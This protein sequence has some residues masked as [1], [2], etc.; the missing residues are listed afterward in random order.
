MMELALPV[1]K[2]MGGRELRL[3]TNLHGKFSSDNITGHPLYLFDKPR[4][5][6][7]FDLR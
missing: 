2:Q 5:P 3:R 7:I 1:L 4:L 6:L